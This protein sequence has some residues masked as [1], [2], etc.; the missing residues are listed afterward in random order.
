MTCIRIAT[1]GSDL[2]L[3]QARY[4]AGRIEAELGAETEL[5]LTSG[6]YGSI[7]PSPTTNIHDSFAMNS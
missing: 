6:H 4:V 7:A 1:R 5:V 3:V 2:A